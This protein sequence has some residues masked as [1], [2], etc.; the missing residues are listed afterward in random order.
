[1][2]K[3]LLS[4]AILATLFA[5][6]ASANPGANGLTKDAVAGSSNACR[7]RTGSTCFFAWGDSG[8]ASAY[9]GNSAVFAVRNADLCFNSDTASNTD[10][11]AKATI[12]RVI[13][14]E[15]L[16]GSMQPSAAS[17]SVLT[18]ASGDCFHAV[19]GRYWIET[20]TDPTT[21]TDTV[22]VSVTERR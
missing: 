15:T 7:L 18:F 16:N 2:T 12:Y 1:M 6:P 3:R 17:S 10:S 8:G 4:L 5:M 21:T 11:D 14:A 20:T 9:T 13:N 22:V 19:T